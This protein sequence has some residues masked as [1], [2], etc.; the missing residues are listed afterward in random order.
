[1]IITALSA[2]GLTRLLPASY[3][4]PPVLRGLTD[5]EQ[6]AEIL[7]A[8]EGETNARLLAERGRSSTVDMRELMWKRRQHDLSLYGQSHINAAFTYT[9]V[10]GNRFND[11]SR[12]AWYCSFDVQVSLAE[13]AFHRSRELRYIGIFKDECRY[14]ELLADF[15]GEFADLSD[16]P[17][18][19]ALDPDPAIGY[20]LGQ[21][22]A[23]Q[24]QRDGHAALLYP[25]VRSPSGQCLVAFEASIIQNVRPG[26]SWDLIW[27]GS[28]HYQVQGV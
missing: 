17:Q 26:A 5:N 23:R 14:V 27:D 22:L 12:G 25:S 6:E 20:P 11:D 2:R 15:I 24:V 7:A 18:H 4:K 10:G 8:I 3:H 9:R 28:E 13:V 16:E 19:P 1:M 21:A